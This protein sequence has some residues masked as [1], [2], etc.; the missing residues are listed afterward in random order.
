MGINLGFVET[1]RCSTSFTLPACRLCLL[2]HHLLSIQH[3]HLLRVIIL[4]L[5]RPTWGAMV[6][7]RPHTVIWLRRWSLRTS[8]SLTQ[9]R[10]AIPRIRSLVPPSPSKTALV[11]LKRMSKEFVST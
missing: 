3:L 10:H 7:T 5:G 9:R 11:L 2:S 4:I 6:L 8:A 1:S